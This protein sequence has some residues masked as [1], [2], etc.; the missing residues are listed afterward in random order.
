[1]SLLTSQLLQARLLAM[2][3]TFREHL[4][5]T[6]SVLTDAGFSLE[7]ETYRPDVFGNYSAIFTAPQMQIRLVSDRSQVFVDIG[8]ADGSWCDKEVLLEQAG[9]P[10]TRHPLNEIGLWSGYCEDVQARDLEQY[11]QILI[12]AAGS[13]RPT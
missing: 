12:A 2:T 7:I 1:M 10:R 11:L 4:L 6:F 13:A 3:A 8:L 9:I 5:K